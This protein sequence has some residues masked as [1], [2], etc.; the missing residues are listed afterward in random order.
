MRLLLKLFSV[1]RPSP[2]SLSI[3][4][5]LKMLVRPNCSRI[6]NPIMVLEVISAYFIFSGEHAPRLPGSCLHTHTLFIQSSHSVSL[7]TD[8]YSNMCGCVLLLIVTFFISGLL[9]SCTP[10]NH[11]AA[12]ILILSYRMA[13]HPWKQP[14]SVATRR[15]L[16]FFSDL[17]PILICRTR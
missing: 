5:S 8:L 7:C 12:V 4:F 9:K 6:L 10:Q 11:F 16:S 1:W 13:G 3:K 14:A 15:L 2:H 17:G